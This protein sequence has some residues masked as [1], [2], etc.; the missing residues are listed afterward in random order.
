[1]CSASHGLPDPT[2]TRLKGSRLTQGKAGK[3]ADDEVLTQLCDLLLE[4]TRGPVEDNDDLAIGDRITQA[5]LVVGGI[6]S[7]LPPK[8]TIICATGVQEIHKDVRHNQDR[9]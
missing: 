4:T 5:M 8:H 2:E 1:M 7:N 6:P 3:A 9:S